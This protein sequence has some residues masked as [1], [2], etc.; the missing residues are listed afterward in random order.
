MIL[1]VFAQLMHNNYT[2]FA[3]N[4][5]ILVKYGRKMTL[6]VFCQASYLKISGVL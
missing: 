2:F 3:I 4:E 5:I 6:A 1:F